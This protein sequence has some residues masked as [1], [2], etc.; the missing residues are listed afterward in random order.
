MLINAE[1]FATML[2]CVYPAISADETRAHLNSVLID[3][4]DSACV[5]TDGHRLAVHEIPRN[6]TDGE[7]FPRTMLSREDVSR[8]VKAIG[9]KPIGQAEI[10]RDGAN[11]TVRYFGVTL[12]MSA[13]DAAFPPWRQVMP[14]ADSEADPGHG[15]ALN[16]AY[17]ADA[18]KSFDRAK[19]GTFAV[20]HCGKAQ[21]LD[22]IRITSDDYPALTWIV[23][24]CRTAKEYLGKDGRRKPY[25]AP[26]YCEPNADRRAREAREEAEALRIAQSF[27]ANLSDAAE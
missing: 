25:S 1:L 8:I 15:I 19:R 3:V 12:T 24:P 4:A 23:M 10:V 21:D 20:V 26:R 2:A 9:K 5:A 18:A 13:V 14:S 11:V 6:A 27:G 16:P 17:L 7:A 22:P